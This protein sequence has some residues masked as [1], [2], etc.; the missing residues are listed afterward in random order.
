MPLW[1]SGKTYGPAL[2]INA[3]YAEQTLLPLPGVA[4]GI[5]AMP[6]NHLSL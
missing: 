2:Q 1:D 5:F 4:G 6:E 3:V